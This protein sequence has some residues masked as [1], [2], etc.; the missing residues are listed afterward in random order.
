[1]FL[2]YARE[3]Y[4]K[5]DPTYAGKVSVPVLWD[6]LT[7]TIVNNESPEIIRMLNSEFNEWSKHPDVDFYPQEMRAK[8]DEVNSWIFETINIGVY[9][10]GFAKSQEDYAYSC[11]ALFESLDQVEAIL[12]E[13]RFADC[14]HNND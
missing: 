12:S 3:V 14:P 11:N 10:C 5:S 7:N 2:L 6:K 13:S 9:K 1:M 4:L 8:I